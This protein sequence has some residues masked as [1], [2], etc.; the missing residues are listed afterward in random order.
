[1]RLDSRSSRLIFSSLASL[2]FLALLVGCEFEPDIDPLIL[3]DAPP[4]AF[5]S[6]SEEGGEIVEPVQQ[7]AGGGVIGLAGFNSAQVMVQCG[8]QLT[9]G[10]EEVGICDV[11]GKDSFYLWVDPNQVI[12]VEAGDP[13]LLQF[14]QA[15]Q[16]RIDAR[17][18]YQGALGDI[19]IETGAFFFEVAVLLPACAIIVLC[20]ADAAALVLTGVAIANTADSGVNNYID[21]LD[22]TENANFYI[23][24]IQDS[25]EQQCRDT[26]ITGGVP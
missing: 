20:L 16:N 22:E 5:Q 26:Y 21:F 17:E 2:I 4:Q 19:G 25:P 14:Q 18:G 10:D 6:A 24:L 8:D 12:E 9:W 1:M 11:P 7:T 3:P 13:D 15:A 23:C